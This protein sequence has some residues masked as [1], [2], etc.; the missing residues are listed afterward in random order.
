MAT[1]K[2]KALIFGDWLRERCVRSQGVSTLH[3]ALYADYRAHVGEAALGPQAFARAMEAE[4]FRAL[5]LDNGRHRQGVR[6][7]AMVGGVHAVPAFSE[8]AAARSLGNDLTA[9]ADISLS[10]MR[11]GRKVGKISS[12]AYHELTA[13]GMDPADAADL[14][15]QRAGSVETVNGGAMV[16]DPGASPPS[17]AL[18]V[19]P[20]RD[21]PPPPPAVREDGAAASP[22]LLV[23]M[24]RAA[25]FIGGPAVVTVVMECP[26]AEHEASALIASELFIA[27]RGQDRVENGKRQPYTHADD[28]ALAPGELASLAAGLSFAASVPSSARGWLQAR[29]PGEG[30]S[31]MGGYHWLGIFQSLWVRSV[32]DFKLVGVRELLVKAGGLIIAAI[33][34]HDRRQAR[35]L[36][37]EE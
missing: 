28:D 18:S 9:R 37:G 15:L 16:F 17:A 24:Q 8:E 1:A 19:P 29:R 6:L 12:A 10:V 34:S 27:R 21:D 4:G 35:K 13:G 30:R 25:P 7:R 36:K 33:E 26:D 22:R 23:S 11:G 5:K 2:A 3:A 31:P 20:L 32:E 14:L